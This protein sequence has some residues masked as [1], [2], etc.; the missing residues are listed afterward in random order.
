MTTKKSQKKPGWREV[1]HALTGHGYGKP[2]LLT[3]L[4][5]LYKLSDDNRDFFHARFGLGDDPLQAYKEIIEEAMY[6]DVMK[7]GPVQVARAKQAIAR[8]EKAVGEPHGRMELMLFFIERGHAFSDQYGYGD[9]SFFT[10]LERMFARAA[11]L[12]ATMEPGAIERLRP[13]LDSVVE[14]V[15]GIGWGHYDE[16]LRIYGETFPETP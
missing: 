6:P 13:R 4:G 2:E 3:L 7:D 5:D 14:E 10:A 9:E 12:L 15:N 16:L 11:A 1:A 8:Y